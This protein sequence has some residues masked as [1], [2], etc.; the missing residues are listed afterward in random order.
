MVY[1]LSLALLGSPCVCFSQWSADN[2]SDAVLK[3]LGPENFRYLSVGL[4]MGRGMHSKCALLFSTGP[5]HTSFAWADRQSGR[6]VWRAY[7]GPLWLSFPVSSC[8]IL[9]N[10]PACCLLHGGLQP[11]AQS[12]W[13]FLFV[14]CWDCCYY[15][16]LT[17]HMGFLKTHS[18]AGELPLKWAEQLLIFMSYP[19]LERLL[20]LYWMAGMTLTPTVLTW[21]SV[22]YE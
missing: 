14:C 22:D 12:S 13:P 18:Q 17:M 7:Q 21:D 1:F 15:L 10:L 9:I 11:Q 6:D 8:S 3:H 4:C 2:W 5:S 16:Q 19:T 20:W